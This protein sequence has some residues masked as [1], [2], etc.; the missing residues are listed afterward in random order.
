MAAGKQE[1]TKLI[2]EAADPRVVQNMVDLDKL[3]KLF[4]LS[5]KL[6]PI[7]GVIIVFSYCSSINFY[8]GGLTVGDTLFFAFAIIAFGTLYGFIVGA[9]IYCSAN[10]YGLIKRIF[11]RE[12]WRALW[13]AIRGRSYRS[14]FEKISTVFSL[15]FPSLIGGLVL[16]FICFASNK[17]DLTWGFLSTS[18]LLAIGFCIWVIIGIRRDFI[19]NNPWITFFAVTVLTIAPLLI[20]RSLG[21][22]VMDAAMRKVGVRVE[23]ALVDIP[24]SEYARVKATANRAAVPI[25]PCRKFTKERCMLRADVLFQGVGQH[26]QIRLPVGGVEEDKNGLPLSAEIF[27]TLDQKDTKISNISPF[28]YGADINSDAT[29]DFDSATLTKTGRSGLDDIAKKVADYRILGLEVTGHTDRLGSD[30][31]NLALSQQR[32]QS[33]ASYLA[34]ELGNVSSDAVHAHG[35][36]AS[37]PR[38]DQGSCP[39][40]D[41]TAALRDC[42]ADD[43]YVEI[44]IV[45]VEGAKKAGK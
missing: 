24:L 23:H 35:V 18:C 10:V 7:F 22:T 6:I 39:G 3:E 1:N 19:Q 27:V 11:S 28:T 44:D 16:T 5:A 15:V 32:A 30:K 26:V 33:V 36:G 42:L 34:N 20:V 45:A 40:Q 43:R 9:S 12:S 38:L 31:H 13:E 8:P 25:P 37:D 14:I 4:K 41:P 21:H 17:F 2:D 29:F